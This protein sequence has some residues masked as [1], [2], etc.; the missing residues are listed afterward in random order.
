MA[1][2][3]TEASS[4]WGAVGRAR[5]GET[6]TGDRGVVVF[7]RDRVVAAAV[8]GLGHGAAASA[9]AEIAISV[10]E[11]HPHDDVVSL[12]ERCDAELRNGRGVAMSVAS[13]D[14]QRDQMSWLGVGNVEGR[15]I[16]AT[17]FAPT[18]RSLLLRPGVV[19]GHLPALSAD[20]VPV[21]RGD[22]LVLATD[23]VRSDFG[24]YLRVSRSCQET[25]QVILDQYGK[26][27]DDALVLVVRYL[28]ERT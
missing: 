13:F 12:A 18:P 7:A 5:P 22:V 2:P 6:I 4:D 14:T 21:T 9:A 19:G 10:V 24:D 28:G 26:R 1:V 15:L 20:S 27:T 3:E 11:R 16:P 17:P 8:D 25:A 23:G